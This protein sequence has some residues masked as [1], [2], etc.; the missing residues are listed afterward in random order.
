MGIYNGKSQSR[1]RQWLAALSTTLVMVIISTVGPIVQ[2]NQM[3]FRIHVSV[4]LTEFYWNELAVHAGVVIGVV[5]GA[6]IADNLGRKFALLLTPISVV[7]GIIEYFS[8]SI[9]FN[10]VF[11]VILGIS[12]GITV[13]AVPLYISEIADDEIRGNLLVLQVV[14]IQVWQLLLFAIGHAI[15]YKMVTQAITA[16][17]LFFLLAFIWFPETPYYLVSKKKYEDA[18]K[19]LA[20]FRGIDETRAMEQLEE[21]VV[22]IQEGGNQR[23][24]SGKIPQLFQWRS[25]K[26]LLIVGTLI[27][28]QWQT[29]WYFQFHENNSYLIQSLFELPTRHLS[30]IIS[31]TL[32]V[33]FYGI[34]CVSIN[35]FGAKLCLVVAT[36]GTL[37]MVVISWLLLE[38]SNLYVTA[39]GMFFTNICQV[40]VVG[41]TVGLVGALFSMNVKSGA[42]ILLVIFKSILPILTFQLFKLNVPILSTINVVSIIVNALAFLITVLFVPNTKRKSLLEIQAQ[43]AGK[44]RDIPR[45]I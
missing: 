2:L 28:T 3:K 10:Y 15:N 27:L 14:G 45:N 24:T 6:I 31:C 25:V 41:I 9:G 19:S 7:S 8:T 26:G 44:G 18:A 23:G 40:I 33:I 30:N 42:I 16:I 36:V 37:T 29:H 4:D 22:T 32:Q 39:A 21:V 38:V 35:A 12:V 34:L 43:M 1:L 13:V 17:P 20:F 11:L 5:I